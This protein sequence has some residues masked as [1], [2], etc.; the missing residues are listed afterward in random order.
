MATINYVDESHFNAYIAEILTELKAWI[1]TGGNIAIKKVL[2]SNNSL[3]FYKNPESAETD[4]PQYKID[5]PIE[6][7]LD[8]AKTTLVPR[9]AWSE[10]LYPGSVNPGL[11]GKPVFVLAVRGISNAD[12][13]T[14]TVTYSFL[15]MASI[16][17]LSTDADNSLSVGSDGGLYS[18]T[19]DTSNLRAQV[20]DLTAQVKELS[21]LCQQLSDRVAALENQ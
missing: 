21:A 7:F 4:E 9:F 11:E 1:D 10:E 13:G 20:E 14:G 12:G 6:R 17:T 5:L 8:Q 18:P 3:L 19:V 16:I 2:F 15:N